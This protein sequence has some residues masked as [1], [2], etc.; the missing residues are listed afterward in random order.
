MFSGRAQVKSGLTQDVKDTLLSWIR[1]GKYPP[2]TQLP[3]VPELVRQLQVSRTVVREALQALVGMNLIQ[4]RPG[5]GCFVNQIPSDLVVNADVLASLLGMEAIVDVVAA[6]KV[7]EAAVARLAAVSATEDDLEEME[8]ILRKIERLAQKNQPMYTLTPQFHV[9]VARATHNKVL[10]KIVSS[11]NLLMAAGGQ[12]IERENVGYQYRLSEYESHREL[13]EAL[14]SRDPDR[15]QHVMEEHVTETLET[16][17]GL[18][19]AKPGRL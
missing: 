4:M 18:S 14:R 19:N 11:F 6:R 16:L 10:E 3:S 2:G 13:F 7:I 15:A 12:L 5:L 1:D 8:E 17:Q 9:A